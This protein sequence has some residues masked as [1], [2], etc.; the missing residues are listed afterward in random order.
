MKIQVI[1]YSN[2]QPITESKNGVYVWDGKGEEF[3]ITLNQ[4]GDLEIYSNHSNIIVKPNVANHITI[5]TE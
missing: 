5:K 2:E 1:D 4:F 3:R